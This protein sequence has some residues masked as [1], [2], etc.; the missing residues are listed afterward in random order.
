MRRC[1]FQDCFIVL[2]QPARVAEPSA[3]LSKLREKTCSS[4]P[5]LRQPALP[6]R[7]EIHSN[8]PSAI[9]RESCLLELTKKANVCR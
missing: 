1:S 2:D 9:A 6:G 7:L 8:I 5:F 4:W 3:N